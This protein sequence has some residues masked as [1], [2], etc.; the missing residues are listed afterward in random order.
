MLT[1]TNLW[2]AKRNSGQIDLIGLTNDNFVN[3]KREIGRNIK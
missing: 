1:K 2:A 3:S